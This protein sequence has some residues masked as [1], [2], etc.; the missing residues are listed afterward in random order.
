LE[1]HELMK[2]VLND[3]KNLEIENNPFAVFPKPVIEKAL[4]VIAD[5][6]EGVKSD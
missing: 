6:T 2:V 3:L 4:K 1:N 5:F